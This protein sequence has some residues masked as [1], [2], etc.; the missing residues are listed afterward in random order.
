MRRGFTIAEL[1]V[2]T[3]LTV[4]VAGGGLMVLC[5]TRN[6]ENSTWLSA[7]AFEEAVHAQLWLERDLA[8]LHHEPDEPPAELTFD[9][10]GAAC[11]ITFTGWQ[12][13]GE[14]PV[15][16][17]WQFDART[18]RLER[19]VAGVATGRFEL[20]VGAQVRFSIVDPGY[21]YGE[22]PA[23]GA[24]GNR[25]AFRITSAAQNVHG[26][27]ALTLVGAA[28]LR[29]KAARDTFPFWNPITKVAP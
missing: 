9:G 12:P 8:A 27:K 4:M 2:T 11:G 24:F 5:S 18:G 7:D 19:S 25:I 1:A 6:A 20:G 10:S 23:L 29:L 28:P 15:P 21:A 17:R 26:R 13:H 22:L 3:A 16:L 14:R